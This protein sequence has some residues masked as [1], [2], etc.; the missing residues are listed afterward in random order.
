MIYFGNETVVVSLIHR[1]RHIL[2][3]S[4]T[5]GSLLNY[6]LIGR[7]NTTDSQEEYET[8][9]I[10]QQLVHPR[11]DKKVFKYDIMLLILE[12]APTLAVQYM[13][14]SKTP[15]MLTAGQDLEAVG[16]GTTSIDDDRE[17]AQILQQVTL[18]YITNDQCRRSNTQGAS[19]R[20]EVTE[21]MF[22]TLTPDKDHCFGDSGGPVLLLGATPAEDVQVGIVSW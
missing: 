1:L 21:D 8:I 7:Y 13:R 9:P 3:V 11:N 20:D 17:V 14:I 5:R 2:I 16:W 6:A 12:R 4:H 10:I 19:Y 22:C 15:P 18:Q